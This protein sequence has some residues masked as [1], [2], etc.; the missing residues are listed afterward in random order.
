MS[1]QAVSV[2]SM[3]DTQPFF[4]AISLC[5]SAPGSP[6]VASPVASP[7]P[8]NDDQTV[9]TP[10]CESNNPTASPSLDALGENMSEKELSSLVEAA[11]FAD[12]AQ[13]L[14]NSTDEQITND[15]R[16]TS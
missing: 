8:S 11:L 16:A 13:K 15:S 7:G 4:E 6:V 2:M 12:A 14:T 10:P 5:A 3:P 9:A 1:R